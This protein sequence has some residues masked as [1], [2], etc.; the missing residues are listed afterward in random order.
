MDINPDH[1]PP[2]AQEIAECIGLPAFLRLVEW[3]G[4]TYAYVPE[5]PKP[6]HAIVQIIGLEATRKL[7]CQFADK[8]E[9]PKCDAAARAA[10][11]AAIAQRR[12]NGESE[13]EVALDT[14]FS[15]R[16]IRVINARHNQADNSEQQELF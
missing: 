8:L 9:I 2:K 7:A 16:W 3:R 15:A 12:A 11:H 4:G 13:R 14:G 6:S 5:N 1:L 10:L